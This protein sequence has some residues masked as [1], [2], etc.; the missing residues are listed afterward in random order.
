MAFLGPLKEK[1]GDLDSLKDSPEK[2]K[3]AVTDLIQTIEDKAGSIELPQAMQD[4]LETIKE[5]L[6][7]LRDYL[8][9]EVQQSGIDERVTSI[10]DSV[11]SGLGMSGK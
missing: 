10:M 11:K 5:K 6:V 4:G 7:A 1:F 3:S 9:G 8:D 2:L